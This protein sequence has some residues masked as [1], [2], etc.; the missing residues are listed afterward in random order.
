MLRKIV[1][2]IVALLIVGTVWFVL[3]RGAQ[4]PIRP[5]VCT[6]CNVLLITIDTLRSDRVGAFGGPQGLTPNLDRLASEMVIEYIVPPRS[7]ATDIQVG[8]RIPGARVRGLGVRP[9]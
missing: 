2:A 6:G 1:A 8:V 3:R 4:T 5:G 9:R 7:S